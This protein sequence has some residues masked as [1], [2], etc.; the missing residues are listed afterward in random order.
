MH[1]SVLVLAILAFALSGAGPSPADGVLA[2]ASRLLDEAEI[3]Y[4]Y[5]GYQVGDG[6]ACQTCNTCLT[7]HKPAP[8]KRLKTCPVCR[9]CSLDCSHF[10][11]LVYREAGL[12][13]PYLDT[14]LMLSLSA[15]KLR[16]NYRLVDLDRDLGRSAPGDLLVY[17]GHV[18]LLEKRHAQVQGQAAFRGDVVHA[19][20]GKDIRA[21]GQG[22]Q[23]E[24]FIDLANFRGPLRRIL[25]PAALVAG[26]PKASA[27]PVALPKKEAKPVRKLRPVAK[28]LPD[29]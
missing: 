14:A 2:V 27:E 20:G 19:T 12:P 3:S 1:R 22:I 16:S 8:A 5:G 28:S 29:E 10:T 15:E 18:V 6:E 21:P 23:R 11:E 24:R 26:A 17:D 13:Y 25:R 4:V 9:S 7:E